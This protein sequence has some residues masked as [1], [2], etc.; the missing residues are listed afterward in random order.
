M[1]ETRRV[2]LIA[3]D[4]SI[5]GFD[6]YVDGVLD[7]SIVASKWVIKAVERHCKDI[8]RSKAGGFP[9]I[10]DRAKA[11]A[12]IAVFPILFR[13]TVGSYAD[14][15]FVLAPWQ[16][17]IVG[18]LW[19]WR[20]DD[21]SRRFRKSY[22]TL[23]RKQGKST[24][25]AGIAILMAC[26]DGEQQAQVYLAATKRDQAKL[27]YDEAERMIKRSPHLLN[28]AKP[29]RAEIRIAASNSYIKMLCSD[30]A[31]DGLNPHCVVLD[32]VHAYK[33]VH[34]PF[35]NTIT[36]GSA[37][38]KQPLELTIT[39]AGDSKSL[40]WKQQDSY[41]EKVI[42]GSIQDERVF[43]F[44]A[45]LDSAEELFDES[46]WPKAMPNLGVSVD[47]EYIRGQ[48]KAAEQ[49]PIERNKFARYFG[50]I[51]VS[52][53]EQAISLEDWDACQV[54]EL[55]D[56]RFA[57]SVCTALDA[58]GYGDLFSVADVA[59]FSEGLD[60]DGK[61]DFRYEVRSFNYMDGSTDRDLD[62]MP[63]HNWIYRGQLTLAQSL[64]ATVREETTS[65]M[66]EDGISEVG[67]DPFNMQQMGE[68]LIEEGFDAK[69]IAQN[70]FQL[71]EPIN[72]LLD[73][74]RRR[75]ISHDGNPIL[76]WAIGN[77]IINSDANNR[78]MP[79]RKHSKDK[80]DPAVALIM[81]LRLAS[82][83][84]Q[85]PKGSLFIG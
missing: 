71:H 1:D 13:H 78:W 38:R 51:E 15:P 25:A 18:S 28:I 7:G 45:R 12:A 43:A 37:S 58:G 61:E 24:I 85:K 81:A 21:G 57:D 53:L 68:S 5:D 69:K 66:Y 31:F 36:T 65:R 77:L 33:E 34:R 32:E 82:L 35:H 55:S 46:A 74:V 64:Y 39:T 48:A 16:S 9:Y 56:W 10:F 49:D 60:D 17:F 14:S 84:K 4:R 20:C 73:L 23:A 6:R 47:I 80:I 50:N 22:V 44:I 52:S 54:E 41:A 40:I 70:R 76:R 63:W 3:M 19:G 67:F 59:K 11:D 62:E 26:L 29:M 2:E 42:D 75:K 8:E 72:L 30:K 79:D 27:V 83:A